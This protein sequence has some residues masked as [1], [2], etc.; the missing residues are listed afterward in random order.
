MRFSDT[1]DGRSE[2]ARVCRPFAVLPDMPLDAKVEEG[3][4]NTVAGIA[5]LKGKCPKEFGL[6]DLGVARPGDRRP[7]LSLLQIP[8]EHM[9]GSRNQR[10][11]AVCAWRTGRLV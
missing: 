1:I 2:T 7:F 3:D 10:D 5:I 6:A 11:E 4:G 9:A 8:V